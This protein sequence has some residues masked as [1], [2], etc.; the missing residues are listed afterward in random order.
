[1]VLPGATSGLLL[2]VRNAL[3]YEIN[4]LKRHNQ[5]KVKRMKLRQTLHKV[6]LK[7]VYLI[8]VI[9]NRGESYNFA[10]QLK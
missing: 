9:F 3:F 7:M 1:M 4:H 8:A 6:I 10:M 2:V 5:Q